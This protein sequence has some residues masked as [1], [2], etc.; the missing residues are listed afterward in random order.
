MQRW[1][2]M[3]RTSLAGLAG[4]VAIGQHRRGERRPLSGGPEIGLVGPKNCPSLA[5]RCRPRYASARSFWKMATPAAAIARMPSRRSVPVEARTLP[6]PA[7]YDFMRQRLFAGLPHHPDVKNPVLANSSAAS[8]YSSSVLTRRRSRAQAPRQA[9]VQ[10]PLCLPPAG[11]FLRGTQK[12][13][14]IGPFRAGVWRRGKRQR[15]NSWR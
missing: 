6:T 2:V 4:Q 9:H 11:G 5:C 15:G 10:R 14:R 1:G 13:L 7:A 12:P 3:V 8:G